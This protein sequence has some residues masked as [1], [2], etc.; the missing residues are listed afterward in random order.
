MTSRRKS[1]LVVLL[2]LLLFPI[3]LGGA[4]GRGLGAQELALWVLLLALWLAAFLF[5]G[6]K[7]GRSTAT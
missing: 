4:V 5:W 6:G 1:L 3:M 7:T 2:I